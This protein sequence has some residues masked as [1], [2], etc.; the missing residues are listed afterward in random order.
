MASAC[1]RNHGW[2]SACRGNQLP[3]SVQGRLAWSGAAG[4]QRGGRGQGRS[5]ARAREA[6]AA[7][8]DWNDAIFGWEFRVS[9]GFLYAGLT[10]S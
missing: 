5:R 8:C 9:N 1:R 7:A 4:R 10:G 2:A 3:I 6:A